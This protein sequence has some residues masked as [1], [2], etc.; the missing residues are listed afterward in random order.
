MCLFCRY[1]AYSLSLSFSSR[2]LSKLDDTMTDL[3]MR[4]YFSNAAICLTSSSNN[5][6]K[7][8]TLC[9]SSFIRTLSKASLAFMPSIELFFS[10]ISTALGFRSD[11][12]GSPL[13][14]SPAA[15]RPSIPSMINYELA[16]HGYKTEVFDIKWSQRTN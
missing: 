4:D 1:L 5:A 10:L 14:L 8:S 16:N 3:I 7:V 13:W 6:D 12:W 2:P 15:T 9:D 11:F